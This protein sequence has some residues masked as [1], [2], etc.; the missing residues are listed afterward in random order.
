[1]KILAEK[2]RPKTIDDCVIPESTKKQIKGLI[3]SG[4]IP[5]MLFIGGA[6]CG[7]TTVARAIAAEMGA[8][9]LFINASMEGN[10][11]T[12]RTRM[13]QFASTVSFTNSKKITILDEADGTSPAAQ[14]ALRGF[15][16]EF[17]K[18][19]SIIFTA[20]FASK[21][22]D[23]IKSRCSVVD[24]KIPGNEKTEIATKFLKR[25]LY[26]LNQEGIEYDMR[27]VA[28]LV[29]KK[30]P[31][32]RSVLNELQAYAAGGKIDSGILL[33]LSDAD[34]HSLI[35]SLKD[36]KF[37]DVRKWVAEHSDV[38]PAYVFKM[39]YDTMSEKADTKSIPEIILLICDY[40]DKASRVANQEIN[41]MGF[42]TS[43]MVNPSI[44]WK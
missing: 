33:N 15:I 42:M 41:T 43:M 2:W 17:S 40:Q 38:D 5:S 44:K 20:N 36:K 11:D 13:L 7:K 27:S 28:E 23:P 34:F 30:F 3:E 26:I 6:G 29:N 8:D 22:I 18:N 12:I 4:N 39:F 19:H 32:F 35:C 31:D 14:G 10:I 9:L 25:V 1:M 16:E 37:N 21:I 24:F